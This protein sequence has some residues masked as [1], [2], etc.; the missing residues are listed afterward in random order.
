M[1][2][3]LAQRREFHKWIVLLLHDLPEVLTI[4]SGEASIVLEIILE[5]RNVDRHRIAL[6]P[7][8]VHAQD[9]NVNGTNV[10][11][12]LNLGW[13]QYCKHDMR[14][15]VGDWNDNKRHA[16][17]LSSQ[18]SRRPRMRLMAGTRMPNKMSVDSNICCLRMTK[19]Q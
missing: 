2:Y 12:C 17:S 19:I 14:V 15:G 9:T 8:A 4:V 13:E 11:L 10:H 16:T 1:Q 3:L 6:N 5:E 18:S 7:P